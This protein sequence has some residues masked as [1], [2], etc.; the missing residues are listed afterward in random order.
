MNALE[1]LDNERFIQIE[2][3]I[4]ANPSITALQ[5]VALFKIG[6]R[7]EKMETPYADTINNCIMVNVGSMFLGIEK[8]GYTH[9]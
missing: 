5:A 9:S 2:D 3:F 7:W 6:A 4:K 8:D 1:K